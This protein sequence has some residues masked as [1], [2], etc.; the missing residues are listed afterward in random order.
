MRN[1][2]GSRVNGAGY[3]LGANWDR[4]SGWAGAYSDV[5]LATV[6]IVAATYLTVRGLRKHR[7]SE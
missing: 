6:A 4:R 1:P 3:A 5:V 7:G 2:D